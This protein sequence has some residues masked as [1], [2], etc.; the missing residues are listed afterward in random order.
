MHVVNAI[1][2]FP[3][4]FQEGIHVLDHLLWM[5]EIEAVLEHIVHAEV[6]ADLFR[7]HVQICF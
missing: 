6:I 3:N 7:F 4:V 1:I 5:L 2:L